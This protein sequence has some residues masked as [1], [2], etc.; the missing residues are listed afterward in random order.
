MIKLLAKKSVLKCLCVSLHHFAGV[1]ATSVT[2]QTIGKVH[3]KI[4]KIIILTTVLVLHN[5]KQA[6]SII[7][8]IDCLV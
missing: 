5:S 6:I 3:D 1:L 7:M 4:H 2:K 8:I